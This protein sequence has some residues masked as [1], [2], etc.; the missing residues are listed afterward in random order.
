MDL[1]WKKAMWL[2]SIGL[3]LGGVFA[4]YTGKSGWPGWL[5]VLLILFVLIP[6]A[7]SLVAEALEDSGK[8]ARKGLSRREQMVPPAGIPIPRP[9]SRSDLSR[10][11]SVAD[12]E[13]ALLERICNALNSRQVAWLRTFDFSGPWLDAHARAVLDLDPLL[14]ELADAPFPPDVGEAI[15]ALSIRL[16]SFRDFYAESTSYDPVFA[17]GEWRFFFSR[18][19]EGESVIAADVEAL[20]ARMRQLSTALADAYV[21][22]VGITA[23]VVP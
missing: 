6:A 23:G 22:L 18:H 17:A 1:G 12:H 8:K 16:E 19:D 10:I 14:E 21:N 3:V 13:I 15:R 7:V 11:R 2:T 9:P 20:Q 5:V 4:G